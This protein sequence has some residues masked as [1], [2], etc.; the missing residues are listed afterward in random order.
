VVQELLALIRFRNAHPAFD[1]HFQVRESG[2]EVL[3]LRWDT[4]EH[5]AELRLNLATAEGTLNYS[6]VP[7]VQG[8]EFLSG[9]SPLPVR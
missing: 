8:P 1:G 3:A 6:A 7:D 5:F 4:P 2:A 9:R